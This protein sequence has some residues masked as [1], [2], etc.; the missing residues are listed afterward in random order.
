MSKSNRF[1]YNI[2]EDE[3]T[4]FSTSRAIS[5]SNISPLI[6]AT[7]PSLNLYAVSSRILL[8]R[9][10]SKSTRCVYFWSNAS[11]LYRRLN[12]R[13]RY[14]FFFSSRMEDELENNIRRQDE[15]LFIVFLINKY[16]RY[17]SDLNVVI[18]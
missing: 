7:I 15:N 8:S 13:H 18:I 12:K 4:N 9:I 6:S 1:M 3:S 17:I 11:Y 10:Y 16:P 14:F 2:F 5:F